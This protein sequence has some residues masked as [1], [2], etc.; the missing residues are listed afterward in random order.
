MSIPR[1][2]RT[3][4]THKMEFTSASVKRP[5][6]F[7]SMFFRWIPVWYMRFITTKFSENLILSAFLLPG[8]RG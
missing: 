6:R 5:S 2:I 3:S 4:E 1:D 7:Y 8:F